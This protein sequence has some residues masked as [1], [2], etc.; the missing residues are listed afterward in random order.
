MSIGRKEAR[1]KRVAP[2]FDIMALLCRVDMYNIRRVQIYH[3]FPGPAAI[4]ITT[5]GTVSLDSV[6][7][8][9]MRKGVRLNCSCSFPDPAT[10]GADTVGLIF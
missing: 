6:G 5:I 7:F 9:R 4:R 8:F 1:Q 2:A 10:N 3:S